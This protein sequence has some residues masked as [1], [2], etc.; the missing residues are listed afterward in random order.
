MSE[1][2]VRVAATPWA[3]MRGLL[4]RRGLPPGEGLLIRPCNAIHTLG[5]RFAIDARFY[6]RRGRLVREALGLPPGRWWVWGGRRARCVLECAAGD[7]AFR[8]C[9]I[10]PTP[11]PEGPTR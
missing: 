4:G 3:R 11:N 2:R 8:E 10:L 7:P 5:M 1:P 6:D 9:A